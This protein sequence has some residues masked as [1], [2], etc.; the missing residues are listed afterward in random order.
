MKCQRNVAVG[1]ASS[2]QHHWLVVFFLPGN[3]TTDHQN[4]CCRPKMKRLRKL[5]NS[6]VNYPNWRYFMINK[7]SKI[8]ARIEKVTS[9]WHQLLQTTLKSVFCI[10]LRFHFRTNVVFQKT[11]ASFGL[12]EAMNTFSCPIFRYLL[13]RK[14]VI[15]F[16]AHQMFNVYT[17]EQ[18]TQ[19]VSQSVNSLAP[20]YA[21]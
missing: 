6:L 8:W 17:M 9:R 2:W 7:Q 21:S 12:A 11:Y 13:N 15:H 4:P 14:L 16:P 18:W 10:H 1:L 20:C 3:F 5:Y 19:S